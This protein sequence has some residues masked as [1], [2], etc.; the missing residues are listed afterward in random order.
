M[1]VALSVHAGKTCEAWQSYLPAG[2]I[3]LCHLHP[4]IVSLIHISSE[5]SSHG[6][7]HLHSCYGTWHQQE[8][9]THTISATSVDVTISCC[10]HPNPTGLWCLQ[11]GHCSSLQWT[12][13]F[14]HNY[15]LPDS[16]TAAVDSSVQEEV[17]GCTCANAHMKKHHVASECAL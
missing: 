3:L 9:S 16:T 5:H 2:Y 8:S 12:T 11:L 13:C 4:T 10:Y 1:Y 6:E 14:C 7:Q 15:L 17:S